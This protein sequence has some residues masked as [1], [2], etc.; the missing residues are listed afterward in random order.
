MVSFAE[1]N[2][3][4]FGSALEDL[5]AFEGQ[6]FNQD[7]AI[8][9]GEDIAVRILDHTC[10]FCLRGW[11]PFVPA[12]DTFE[13]VGKFEDVRHFTFWTGQLAHGRDGNRRAKGNQKIPGRPESGR[14]MVF[15]SHPGKGFK[16]PTMGVT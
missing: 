4:G 11:G 15:C 16:K 2:G 9:I 6:V 12:S 7:D 13:V 14:G 10:G 5:C 8:A 3:F 1:P